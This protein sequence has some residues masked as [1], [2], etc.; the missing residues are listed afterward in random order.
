M[1]DRCRRSSTTTAPLCRGFARRRDS[2][3]DAGSRT[4][5]RSAHS[6]APSGHCARWCRMTASRPEG[7][8]GVMASALGSKARWP[9]RAGEAARWSWCGVRPEWGRR[10]CSTM[11]GLGRAGSGLSAHVAPARRTSDPSRRSRSCSSPCSAS[12]RACQPRGRRRSRPRSGSARRIGR[13]I[14]T[15][16]TPACSTVSPRQRRRL[17]SWWPSTTRTCWTRPR[18]RPSPSSR[19][20]CGSTASR[21]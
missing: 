13:W 17:R 1:P 16:S 14:A 7:C 2:C 18:P 6:R 3:S 5:S 11:P 20:A 4:R 9:W 21:S 12:S 8:S 19:G 15:R 10:R